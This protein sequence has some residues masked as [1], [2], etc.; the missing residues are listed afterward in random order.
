M[1]NWKKLAS[2]AAG[3]AGGAGG[4]NVE[5]VFSNYIYDGTGTSQTI[6]NG[7][8]L[9]GEGGFVWIK[10]REQNNYHYLFDTE[11]T[12][13]THAFLLP[14]TNAK[15]ATTTALTSFNSDG[16]SLGSNNGTNGATNISYASWTFR[17][18][19]KFFDIV[20]YTGNGVSGR[21]I[22]HNLGCQAGMV[23]VKRT[24][25]A[26]NWAVWHR[27]AKSYGQTDGY[28]QGRLETD[29][30][31][32]YVTITSASSTTFT[33][34]TDTGVNANGGSYVAYIFAHNDGDGDFG[35]TGDQDI[36]KCGGYDSIDT[37][38]EP[39][40]DLGFEPQW[41]LIKSTSN[42]DNW[43]IIDNI[44]GFI[45]T[46]GTGEQ[47]T[48]ILRAN[49][50]G[51]ETANFRAAYLTHKGFRPGQGST[52]NEN[53]QSYIYVAIR[54]PTGIPVDAT[55]VFDVQTGSSPFTADFPVDLALQK[56]YTQTGNWHV[57]NR[58]IGDTRYLKTNN[59]DT[60][61]SVN[62]QGFDNM[63]EWGGT[64]W[65]SQS[66]G[67]S[68]KRA[69]GYFDVVSYTGDGSTQTINHNLGVVPEMMWVKMRRDPSFT[70]GWIVY[71]K[72][73]GTDSNNVVLHLDTSAAQ[74]DGAY[75]ND[76]RP[77]D[78]SF[79]VVGDAYV[80]RSNATYIAYLFATVDG[81][82]KVGTYTGNGTN[83]NIDCGFSNGARFVLVKAASAASNWQVAGD[84]GNGIVAGSDS[85]LRFDLD[86]SQVNFDFIDPYSAGFTCTGAQ[87]NSNNVEYIFYAVA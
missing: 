35:P 30:A 19:P 22:S 3:A 7:I 21:Q 66:V 12:T 64:N 80:N 57:I 26:S 43:V 76:E 17:K 51:T 14:A 77:T 18:A 75:F 58:V 83:Q 39:E 74:E 49:E 15:S 73:L 32:G 72:D 59:T 1:A 13:N 40:I 81:V 34:N 4:L 23:I 9:D 60:E 25:I 5:D 50:T 47:D 41:L 84:F 54:R 68:W 33:V 45:A 56:N 85:L 37:D 44:R 24:D 46:R 28:Y 29:A 78:T 82:S 6:T 62:S 11:A 10:V 16:F 71:H 63:E 31:F 42:A 38:G 69:T 48:P 53:N 86:N 67:F 27:K 61:A 79:K 36:I 70:R 2:G 65:G 52:T 20:T 55:D 8:D 87:L